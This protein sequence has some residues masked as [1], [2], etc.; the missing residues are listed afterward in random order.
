[1]KPLIVANWKCNP[2]TL[3]EAKELFDGVKREVKSIKSIE[4]VIC[5]PFVWLSKL[6]G[7]KLGGQNCYCEEC[8]PYTGEI[9]P[10]MLKDLKCKY[11]IIGHSE[12]RIHLQESDEMINKKIK[13]T[14]TAGLIPIL[15]IGE[16]EGEDFNQIIEQQL[17]IDL[18]DIPKPDLKK[19]I[20][21]Y[22]PIWAISTS[23]G[24]ICS[25][26]Q[27]KIALEFIKNK[28]HGK[29][30]YGGSVDSKIINYYVGVGYGGALVGVASLKVDEFINT[31][32]VA[33]QNV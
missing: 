25:K 1:M 33:E 9:S 18:L 29:I 28:F 4:T 13:A 7:L 10:L 3:T 32:K 16:K 23:G 14:L 22:E 8:G 12:R 2:K 30:I 5:P 17:N 27:A 20:V 26:E 15:C 6:K 11:V 21:A 19:I 31:V 24:E